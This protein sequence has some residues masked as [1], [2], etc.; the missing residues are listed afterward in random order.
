MEWFDWYNHE[1][2]IKLFDV[3]KDINYIPFNPITL[4]KAD[5]N[6]KIWDLLIIHEEDI[7]N[8]KKTKFF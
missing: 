3:I 6:H 2:S 7:E 8:F 1:D 4:E 5:V